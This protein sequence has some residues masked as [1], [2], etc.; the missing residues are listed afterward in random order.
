MDI[1]DT[2]ELLVEFA[3]AAGLIVIVGGLIS[4]FFRKRIVSSLFGKCAG[5]SALTY[6]LVGM[7]TVSAVSLAQAPNTQG[8]LISP[9][10]VPLL[11]DGKKIGEVT[12]PAGT[13]VSIIKK[14]PASGKLLVRSELGMTWVN[15]AYVQEAAPAKPMASVSPLENPPA[16]KMQT[17]ETQPPKKE[18]S[19][20]PAFAV[21][22]NS[23]F[24]VAPPTIFSQLPEAKDVPPKK[25]L[26][27]PIQAALVEQIAT[28]K[29]LRNAGHHVD[30]VSNGTGRDRPRSVGGKKI[31]PRPSEILDVEPV[32]NPDY[33]RYDLIFGSD[34]DRETLQ[35]IYRGQL[36]LLPS[37]KGPWFYKGR[38][39]RS[40]EAERTYL[41]E[42]VSKGFLKKVSSNAKWAAAPWKGDPLEPLPSESIERFRGTAGQRSG[43]RPGDIVRYDNVLTYDLPDRFS[44]GYQVTT[45]RDTDGRRGASDECRNDFANRFLH[46][47]IQRALILPPSPKVAMNTAAIQAVA[48]VP[49]RLTLP[50]SFPL[51]RPREEGKVVA[52]GFVADSPDGNPKWQ[53]LTPPKGLRAV[54]ISTNS[55][56]YGS[57]FHSLALSADGKVTA[58]GANE[59]GQC[60]VPPDLEDVVSV[61]AGDGVSLAI[62]SDGTIRFWGG[63]RL[64]DS[65]PKDLSGVVQATF[66]NEGSLYLFAD[67]RIRYVPDTR[68]VSRSGDLD[69]SALNNVVAITGGRHGYA[70]LN[71]GQLVV[72]GSTGEVTSLIPPGLSNVSA[73][74]TLGS[75]ASHMLVILPDGSLRSWGRNDAGQCDFPLD[76]PPVKAVSSSH[77]HA[78][79]L[80]L[81]DNLITWGSNWNGQ[82]EVPEE[83]RTASFIQA[84]AGRGYTLGIIR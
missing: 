3:I 47:A 75:D 21:S 63:G 69:A 13:K 73:L 18:N 35:A 29:L 83:Y 42:Q 76:L 81:K 72:V 2:L 68:G 53:L 46:P 41:T 11:K 31:S 23:T 30:Y 19:S 64:F 27:V 51:S 9:A 79:A 20:K 33:E 80:S 14:D 22:G 28:A 5:T 44:G 36:V 66:T 40:L 56:G 78:T 43:I 48:G 71:D 49:T 1:T 59:N 37:G 62:K 25:I 54:Q 52:W 55:D 77:D 74:S 45:Y 82:L 67:G 6:A 15:S 70:L 17:E 84:E 57:D 38:D 50:R 26:I 4:G 39:P 12:L 65:I 8:T 16:P 24:N 58:W 34:K 61:V 32:K 60:N 7:L 10:V